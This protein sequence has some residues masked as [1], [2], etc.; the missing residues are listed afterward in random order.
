M[1]VLLAVDGDCD[2]EGERLVVGGCEGEGVGVGDG[3]GDGD[4]VGVGVWVGVGIG[5]GVGVLARFAVIVPVPLIAAVVEAR[6]V[7]ANVMFPVSVVHDEK[8]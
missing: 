2:G 8:V 1:A 6:F 5:V 7:L 3:D 4:A